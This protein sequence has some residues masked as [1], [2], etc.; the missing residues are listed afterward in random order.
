[1]KMLAEIDDRQVCKLQVRKRSAHRACG[2][3]A[4]IHLIS[5]TKRPPNLNSCRSSNGISWMARKE[6]FAIPTHALCGYNSGYGD[7][8]CEKTSVTYVI[9]FFIFIGAAKRI[10]T[11]DPRITNALLYQLSYC[12][13]ASKRGG[14]LS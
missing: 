2:D 3:G 7:T 1:M 10:R 8:T 5:A 9:D 13:A 4:C 6:G 11:P 12:G 14:I